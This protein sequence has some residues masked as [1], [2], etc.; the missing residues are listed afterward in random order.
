MAL[1][2]AV[3][4]LYGVVAYGVD[5]RTRE[6]G[7]RLALGARRPNVLALVI[8]QGMQPTL[9]GVCLGMVGAFAL[10]RSL[11][12]QLYEIK[13]TDPATFG[14]VALGLLF[15]SLCACYVPARRATKIDPLVALRCE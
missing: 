11:A 6:L 8:C 10:M 2:L 5:Q 13:P 7:I 14:L 9:V 4:G 1:L 12:S 3:V 15:V